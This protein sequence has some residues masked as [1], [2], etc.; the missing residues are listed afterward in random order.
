MSKWV[1]VLKVNDISDGIMKTVH[2]GG[3][4]LLLAQVGNDYYAA[5]NRCPHMG[6]TLSMGKLMGTIVTCPR[7]GSEFDLK[8]GHVVRWTNWSGVVA[9]LV[10]VVKSPHPIKVYPAKSDGKQIQVEI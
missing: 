1:T 2:A 5:D 7:H 4:E 8:D 6:S 10:K 3:H 9:A